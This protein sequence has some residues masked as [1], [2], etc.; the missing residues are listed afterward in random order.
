MGALGAT[1]VDWAEAA[2]VHGV[3]YIF[4]AGQVLAFLF[5]SGLYFPF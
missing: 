4:T 1:V 3:Q 2:T 5:L